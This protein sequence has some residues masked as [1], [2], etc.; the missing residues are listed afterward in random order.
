MYLKRHKGDDKRSSRN[1]IC[2]GALSA[3]IEQK[4]HVMRSTSSFPSLRET[5]TTSHTIIAD[6][7]LRRSIGC[8]VP[9]ADRIRATSRGA[10]SCLIHS[11]DR[12]KSPHIKFWSGCSLTITCNRRRR[13][14]RRRIVGGPGNASALQGVVCARPGRGAASAW[15]PVASRPVTRLRLWPSPPPYSQKCHKN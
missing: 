10:G 11:D 1:M 5:D 4:I 15:H 8:V 14:F 9:C 13:S 12:G 3:M 7:Q 2:A 6:I